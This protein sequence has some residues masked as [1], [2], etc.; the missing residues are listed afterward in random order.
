MEDLIKGGA[1]DAEWHDR[2]GASLE[3]GM[4]PVDRRGSTS[5]TGS[6]PPLGTRKTD[7]NASKVYIKHERL[8]RK[9][10]K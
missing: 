2:P 4:G 7:Q 1:I 3:E 8:N 9:I 6:V 5:K 10:L